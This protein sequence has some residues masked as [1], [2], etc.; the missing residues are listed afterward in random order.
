[1][2]PLRLLLAAASIL[3]ALAPGFV[4]ARRPL[5]S[6]SELYETFQRPESYARR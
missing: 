2:K 6:K 3:F 1:M 5:L 4:S